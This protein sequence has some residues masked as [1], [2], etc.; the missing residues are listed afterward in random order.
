MLKSS[1]INGQLSVFTGP[2]YDQ[3][4][5]LRVQEGETLSPVQIVQMDWLVDNVIGSIPK[6]ED[7]NEEARALS[8]V[9]GVLKEEG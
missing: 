1:I 3:E 2:I 4:G 5:N 9:V 7:L 6:N 8:Q